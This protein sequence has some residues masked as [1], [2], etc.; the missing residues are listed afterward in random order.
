MKEAIGQKMGNREGEVW[1]GQDLLK[2]CGE[3]VRSLQDSP[4]QLQ[5][6]WRGIFMPWDSL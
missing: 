2:M 1:K 3:G 4:G 5:N 6:G